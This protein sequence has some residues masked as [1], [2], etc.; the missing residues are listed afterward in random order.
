MHGPLNVK[1]NQH[2]E[3]S[4]ET[5]QILVVSTSAPKH[6]H[7]AWCYKKKIMNL[8]SSL[9]PHGR[10]EI[11]SFQ[12]HLCTRGERG[13]EREREIVT[14]LKSKY[15]PLKTSARQDAATGLFDPQCYSY[16]IQSLLFS[17]HFFFCRLYKQIRITEQ[18]SISVRS[19]LLWDMK[20]RRFVVSYRHFG[21]TYRSRL[22]ESNTPQPTGCPETSVITHQATLRNIP[23]E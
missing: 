21:T 8:T 5:L 12:I 14:K 3:H 15:C 20:Q 10:C 23:E 1:F 13:G 17:P 16:C 7:S 18:C 19:S 2:C 6:P 9:N 22:Q 4:Y 11:L